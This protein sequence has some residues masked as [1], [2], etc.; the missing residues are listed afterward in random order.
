VLRNK[1]GSISGPLDRESCTL[2][3]SRF[4][5]VTK[6]FRPSIDQPV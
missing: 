5:D 6:L 4:R 3:E 1:P 2:P